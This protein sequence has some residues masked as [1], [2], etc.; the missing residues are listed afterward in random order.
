MKMML[1]ASRTSPFSRKVMIAMEELNLAS[2]IEPVMVDPFQPTPEFLAANPLAQ[3]PA[4]VTEKGEILPGSGLIIEYLQTRGHGLTSLPRG[5]Q[6]WVAL[7]R[8]A[9]AEGLLE[10]AVA[11]RYEGLRPQERQSAPWIERKHAAVLRSLD[12][13][14]TCA[15]QLLVEQ[16]SVV[17]IGIGAALGYLDFRFAVL[18]W[19][20]GRPALA[21]W[22]AGFAERP[23][24][25]KTV[26]VEG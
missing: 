24:M 10:A 25:L 8:A 13:L 7:R 20:Q 3:I 23:S 12:A 2:L 16:P 14:E 9:L 6:R 18:G 5:S 19:R 4:L 26:P 17:E 22:Y 21:Q 11:M 1:Y 15:A